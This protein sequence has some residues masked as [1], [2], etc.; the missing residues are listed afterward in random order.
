MEKP[1]FILK[2]SILNALFPLFLKNLFFSSLISI[3]LY[4]VYR[5]I[6]YSGYNLPSIKQYFFIVLAL[7]LALL[8]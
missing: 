3:I 4:F 6:L 5:L 1:L 7:I 2:P 8:P